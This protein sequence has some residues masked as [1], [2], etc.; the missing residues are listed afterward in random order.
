MSRKFFDKIK[1][2]PWIE[3]LKLG[4]GFKLRGADG[5][6]L[7]C[8]G[9]YLVPFEIKGRLFEHHFIIIDNLWSEI[10]L[11]NDF[12]AEK[13]LHIVGTGRSSEIYFHDQ[14]KQAQIA[15]INQQERENNKIDLVIKENVSIPAL[16]A[17]HIKVN[18]RSDKMITTGTMITKS[19]NEE[20]PIL[21]AIT[22][23]D[24]N[25][26]AFV[27]VTN[28]SPYCY[29]F[30]KNQI[31]GAAERFCDYE[32]CEVPS[33]L[34]QLPSNVNIN[35]KV[36][37][38]IGQINESYN[39]TPIHLNT[40]PPKS[41]QER[42]ERIRQQ[43]KL[44]HIKDIGIRKSYEN[45]LHEF[46]DIISVNKYE[47]GRTSALVHKIKLK[48]Q[49]PI[50]K[51]QFRIPLEHEQ[52]LNDYVNQLLKSNCIELSKS[53]YNAPIFLVKK[54][55]NSN[56]VVCDFRFLNWNTIPD[57]YSIRD[58]KDCIDTIGK[59][60]SKIFSSIDLT[61]SFWQ[62]T[63]APESREATAFSIPGRARYHWISM[64]MGLQGATSSFARLMDL[65]LQGI[66][67][68][69]S[70]IDDLVT[71]SS[72]H[73]QQ[74]Q[75]LRNVFLRFR[76][77][78]LKM[79]PRKCKF[80]ASEI[81]YLGVHIDGNGVRPGED[82]ALAIKQFPVPDS[83]KKI[84]QFFGI[85][86]YFRQFI[87]NFA[88]LA[89]PLT[90]LTS[91]NDSWKRGEL[92]PKALES[93]Y[94]LR[95]KL[96]ARPIIMFP[97]QGQRYYLY[98]DASIGDAIHKGGLG[99]VLC[100]KDEL[101]RMRPVAYASRTLRDSENKYCSYRMEIAAGI[102]AI[103]Y[104][105]VYLRGKQFTWFTDNK[106]LV[107]RS[108][109]QQKKLDELQQLLL[110][111]QVEIIHTPKERNILADAL[112]RNAIDIE[113]PNQEQI[114]A[115]EEDVDIGCPLNED[116]MVK[117]QMTDPFIRHLYKFLHY[118]DIPSDPQTAKDIQ[119][120]AKH[121]FI[122][123][124]GLIRRKIVRQKFPLRTPIITPKSMTTRILEAAHKA[125]W[126]GHGGI[127]RTH[128]RIIEHYWWP[129]LA[130]DV[131]QYI[132]HCPTCQL[133]KS[134]PAKPAPLQPI[135]IPDAPNV[136]IH[137]DLMGPLKSFDDNKYI[138]VITDAWTKFMEIVPLKDKSA[139]TI[140]QAFLHKWISVFSVPKQIVTDNGTE[141]ANQIMQALEKK[142][143][144]KHNLTAPYHSQS[145]SPAESF[146]RSIIKYLKAML[147][148][149]TL[150]WVDRLDWL[151]LAYNTTV[152]KTT[153]T[154]PFALTFAFS[155][156]LPYFDLDRPR[157]FYSDDLAT[158]SFMKLRHEF[159]K[160]YANSN[161]ALKKEKEY[162]DRKAKERSFD[163]GDKVMLQ[164]Y[165]FIKKEG[166]NNKFRRNF[167]GPYTV[168]QKNIGFKLQ[169]CEAKL[170][171]TQI[172]THQSD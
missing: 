31:I 96:S 12:I 142:F 66:Q 10:I 126:A 145:N 24:K 79:N 140:A 135:V 74:I 118:N 43:I 112:S 133:A 67:G 100:Q 30:N 141:F 90:K 57:K 70:Y 170:P 137:L 160:A 33:N 6:E 65:V 1:N 108:K 40:D 59:N 106:P 123:D 128:E 125:K 99:A 148:N 159:Q 147:D 93:F 20:F 165:K 95:D 61:S 7:R 97:K 169:N 155:P 5:Q 38:F 115:I 124:N 63:I 22:E 83:P 54:K 50:H 62:M 103:N 151:K 152:H 34:H 35:K 86:N 77:Y 134:T 121:C 92:P 41:P 161:D 85:C 107:D 94:A 172:C 84:R 87:P 60:G 39:E 158:E 27:V 157:T 139:E 168:I 81:E 14:F 49:D 91:I 29:Q 28:N 48:D 32:A 2:N 104:F 138:L 4:K 129:K 98:T 164:E 64:A 105:D 46:Q 131:I 144:F 120:L 82:K 149:D 47:I 80:G 13:R 56:R 76:K 88:T 45:L 166:E 8:M 68:M 16:S 75:I 69:I 25:A 21:E 111:Y 154:T 117:L 150:D 73:E 37:E 51:K 109:L 11:G 53:P 163:V 58:C 17:K 146:N 113:I 167:D 78:N 42:W 156:K 102:W 89:V 3:Q 15:Q 36:K 130:N 116:D 119:N 171:K 19:I 52:E 9:R 136:R 55:D 26:E 143:N 127:F 71:H 44:D 101:N 122:Q 132:A 23:F 72:T 162:Y 18:A 153:L 114:D 110:D